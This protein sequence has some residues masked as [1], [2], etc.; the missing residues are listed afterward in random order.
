M[1]Y[2]ALN[3]LNPTDDDIKNKSSIWLASRIAPGKGN[4][5]IS[6]PDWRNNSTHNGAAMTCL[7]S[8]LMT[9]ALLGSAG[10]AIVNLE[11]SA[12][13]LIWKG[14]WTINDQVIIGRGQV[15]LGL[16]CPLNT[17]NVGYRYKRG[18]RPSRVA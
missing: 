7:N 4:V 6:F 10:N 5:L 15:S 1:E 16:I 8:D 9:T 11:S 3:I 2:N 14:I 12:G 17:Y 18:W 13:S